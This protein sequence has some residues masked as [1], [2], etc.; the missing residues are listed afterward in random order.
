[1]PIDFKVTA[2]LGSFK[3]LNHLTFPSQHRPVF[4]DKGIQPPEWW[5]HTE[6][7]TVFDKIMADKVRRRFL[8]LLM[9]STKSPT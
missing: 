5:K 1:V 8:A 9:F 3:H 4:V 7:M 2:P 6:I